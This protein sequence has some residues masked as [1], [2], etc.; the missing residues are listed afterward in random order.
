MRTALGFCFALAVLS[1]GFVATPAAARVGARCGGFIGLVCGAHEFCQ[2][3]TGACFFADGEGTCVRRPVF[4]GRIY[5]PV[6]GCDGKTY[7]NDCERQR[8][9]VSLAHDGKCF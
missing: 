1:S 6:C 7:G 9:G 5:K 4:C 2:H 3:P 8:A